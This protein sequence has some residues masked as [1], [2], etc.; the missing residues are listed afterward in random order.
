MSY[1]RC[2]PAPC[3]PAEFAAM[4]D[5]LEKQFSRDLAYLKRAVEAINDATEILKTDN[6]AED[7]RLIEQP[8]D[9]DSDYARPMSA[10]NS[11]HDLSRDQ[12]LDDPRH[13]PYRRPK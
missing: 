7:R 13:T 12:K 10:F 8:L 2:Y 3:T 4:M 9:E 6:D 5:E 1:P 11:N